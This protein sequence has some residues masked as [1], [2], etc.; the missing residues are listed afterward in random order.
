M[1]QLGLRPRPKVL[2]I[3]S[4][5]R[6]KRLSL[7]GRLM[8]VLADEILVQWPQLKDLYNDPKVS[9]AGLLV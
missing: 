2:Y 7:T 3:E 8:L 9:Y 1:L 5:T 6:V 4:V